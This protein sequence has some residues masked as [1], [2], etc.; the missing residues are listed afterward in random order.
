M[1]AA[2][3]TRLLFYNWAQFDDP[4]GRGGGVSVY[5]RNLLDELSRRPDLE[6]CFL[7]AG[8]HRSRI[9]RRIRYVETDNVFAGRGV[10][11][12][13]IVN[14]PVRVPGMAMFH[15][16]DLWRAD[17]RTKD[18][19]ERFLHSEGPFDAVHFHNLEGVSSMTLELARMHPDTRFAY[20]WHNY[21]PVCP[22]VHLLFQDNE[23]CQDY[24]DGKQCVLCVAPSRFGGHASPA[25][26]YKLWRDTN[27]NLLNNVFDC[28]IAVSPLAK[29][30]V[31]DM[32]A[33]E[34]SVHVAPLGMDVHKTPDQM[35]AEWTAKPKRDAFTFSFIGY[36]AAYKGL[37]FLVDAVE[38]ASGSPFRESSDLLVVAKLS[39]SQR[40]L[41]RRLEGSFRKVTH[42]N[43]YRRDELPDIARR[44]DVNIVP[45]IW[46]ETFH[47]I[48][49]ELLCTGTPSLLS[50]SVGLRM[51]YENKPDFEFSAGDHSDLVAKMTTLMRHREKTAEFWETPLR[52]PTMQ[53]HADCVLNLVL[54]K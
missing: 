50:S 43:G 18:V 30:T 8:V 46:R 27:L 51:F 32:G 22:Q 24:N 1:S 39:L 33:R 13:A 9:D 2:S 14:S 6:I 10:K 35:R 36:G 34:D 20:T 12:Y 15:D 3:R 17:T 44:I 38:R 16:V 54:G 47:Q 31:V 25:S 41:L 7:S 11:S 19:F 4:K 40:R 28:T 42:I 29:Q 21:I 23:P 52:L 37:P 53:Q 5:L 49:Y 48:G 45:S 26:S